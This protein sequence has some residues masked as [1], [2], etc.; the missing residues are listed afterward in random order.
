M[1]QLFLLRFSGEVTTK[2]RGTRRAF[3]RRLERNLEDALR[4][5][6]VEYDIDRRWGRIFVAS[7]STAAGDAMRHVFG[8]QSLSPVRREEWH[9]LEDIVDRGEDLFTERVT[10]KEFAVR[11]RR[12]GD[13]SSIPFTSL[14]VERA[15]G[16]RLLEPSAGVDLDEPEVTCRVEVRE[17]AAYFFTDT[18]EAPGGLP[19]GTEGRALALVSGGFDSAVAAWLVLKRGVRLDYLFYNLGGEIH[20]EGVLKV[21][22]LVADRWS[23]G[24][25]PRLYAVDLAPAAEALQA[26]VE[27][28]LWQVVLKRLMLDGA[29]RLARRI[30]ADALVTGEAI[31][32]VSS[33]TLQNLRVITDRVELPVLRPLVGSNKNEII[34][35]ARRIGTYELS[36]A[37]AE[38]CALEPDHPATRADLDEVRVEESKLDW[39]VLDRA[40]D[41]A[42]SIDL[43]RLD[44]TTIGRPELAVEAVPAGAE[45]VDLRSAPAYDSWHYPGAERR[46]YFAA[47]QHPDRFDPETTYVFYCEVGL[48]SAHVAEVLRTNGI[49]AYHFRGGLKQTIE[50]AEEDDPAHRALLSPALLTE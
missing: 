9:Q 33:Q 46:D 41:D 30:D 1:D 16:A 21:M 24:Y 45:V 39:E 27:P 13:K 26:R 47:L 29:E 7:S 40:V 11:A 43:R 49:E 35:L 42:E 5:A 34:D 12:G 20:R 28:K 48:K 18:L 8:L 6:G 14:D 19:I 44:L 50:A 38:Y 17:D 22:K 3:S 37:V 10:G 2:A 25:R 32:Q 23:F 31:G 15:L 4:S 36:A